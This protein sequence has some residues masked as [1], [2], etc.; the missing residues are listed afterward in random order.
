MSEEIQTLEW[1]EK[2]GFAEV[3]QYKRQKLLEEALSLVDDWWVEY[4]KARDSQGAETKGYLGVR[5]REYQVAIGI[6]YFITV[7]RKSQDGG[8]NKTFR[9]IP[10]GGRLKYT[11]ARLKRE[12]AKP[13][14]VELAMKW[15][16]RFEKIRKEGLTLA[17][18]AR[19]AREYEKDY[20]DRLDFIAAAYA[21]AGIGNP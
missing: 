11:E 20:Q 16:P 6:E 21:D 10:R 7:F 15:E 19:I 5:V 17:K 2:I 13:W 9:T 8:T 3:I 18:L 12:R 14:E 4:T 1:G